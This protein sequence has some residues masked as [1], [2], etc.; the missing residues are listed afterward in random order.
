MGFLIAQEKTKSNQTKT[1]PQNRQPQNPTKPTT[2]TKKTHKETENR[3][4]GKY[5]D[6]SWETAYVYSVALTITAIQSSD[7]VYGMQLFCS[8]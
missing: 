6:F 2:I 3:D 1:K 5:S 8:C 7:L 4:Y